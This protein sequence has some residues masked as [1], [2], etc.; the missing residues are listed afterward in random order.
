MYNKT[1]ISVLTEF[2]DR[3]RLRKVDSILSV[4]V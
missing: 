1:F 2:S 4:R 3:L